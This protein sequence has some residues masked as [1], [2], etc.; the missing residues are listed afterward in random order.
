MGLKKKIYHDIK[1]M[2]KKPFLP[3]VVLI[4][5]TIVGTIGY[6]ILW[7]DEY[8]AT[9]FDAFYMTFITIATIGYAEIFP[10]DI[11]GR[12]FTVIIALVGISSLFFYVYHCYGKPL[13]SSNQ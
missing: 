12:I 3:A 1:P 6:Y 8:D 9:L 10:L 2:L 11:F 5:T 4:T 13:Y 7:I